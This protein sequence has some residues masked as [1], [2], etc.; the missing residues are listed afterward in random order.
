MYKLIQETINNDDYIYNLHRDIAI[1]REFESLRNNLYI[2]K[3]YMPREVEYKSEFFKKFYFDLY[4][5][6]DTLYS[7][8]VLTNTLHYVMNL[9]YELNLK[10][11]IL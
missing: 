7:Q 6:L 1:Y 9:V 10:D 5:K 11:T 8:I 4:H 2:L 3:H